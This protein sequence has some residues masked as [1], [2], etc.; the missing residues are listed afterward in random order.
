MTEQEIAGLSPAF[1][2]IWHSAIFAR[3]VPRRYG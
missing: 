1:A 3:I 2:A